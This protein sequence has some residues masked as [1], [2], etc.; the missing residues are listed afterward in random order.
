[1][2]R[3]SRSSIAL[4]FTLPRLVSLLPLGLTFALAPSGPGAVQ[5]S[6]LM[7]RLP[8]VSALKDH[9]FE[10]DRSV[11]QVQ[12]IAEVAPAAPSAKVAALR[13]ALLPWILELEQQFQTRYAKP[14]GLARS[15]DS[16]RLNVLVVASPDTLAALADGNAHR[17][18]LVGWNNYDDT[19]DAVVCDLEF[20]PSTPS[21]SRDRFLRGC[22][23]A[24][25]DDHATPASQRTPP[26]V[27]VLEGLARWFG[28][29]AGRT[30]PDLA[31]PRVG[32]TELDV[33]MAALADPNDPLHALYDFGA[34]LELRTRD[35][36][37][38]VVASLVKEKKLEATPDIDACYER[39]ATLCG[40]W[41]HYL[42]DI[43]DG[44]Y[45]RA[46]FTYLK[47][48]SNGDGSPL[49]LRVALGL[50]EL[51]PLDDAFKAWAAARHRVLGGKSTV[52]PALSAVA[53]MSQ[54]LLPKAEAFDAARMAIAPS[55]VAAR[56]AAALS[57]ARSGDIDG[58]RSE[59]EQLAAEAKD[60]PSLA[61]MQR[62]L[63][64]AT[65][66]LEL[67][68]AWIDATIKK[69]AKLAW[70]Q[71]G[72]KF[73]A[74]ITARTA[75]ALQLG[76]NSAGTTELRFSEVDSVWLAGL[77]PADQAAGEQA[78]KRLWPMALA[79]DEK[80][81]ALKRNPGT[82]NETL[83]ADAKERYAASLALGG[84][85]A[86]IG[87]LAAAGLPSDASAAQECLAR[88]TK[89]MEAG[90]ES[91]LVRARLE[92]INALVAGAAQKTFDAK[93]H[94]ASMAAAA[95]ELEGGKWK[96][97]WSFTG[98]EEL[99]AFRVEPGYLRGMRGEK[100]ELKLFKQEKKLVVQKGALRSQGQQLLR[101][102]PEFKSPFTL[103][104]SFAFGG[105]PRGGS[106]LLDV[107][108][109]ICD[110]QKG[111]LLVL[112]PWGNISVYAPTGKPQY[113]VQA[114]EILPVRIDRPYAVEVVH[115][116]AQVVLNVDGA[117]V[118][119]ADP[120]GRSSG[121]MLFLFHSDATAAM[122][123]VE[124]EGV[125]DLQALERDHLYTLLTSLGLF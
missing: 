94:L 44:R 50:K 58:A 54:N 3:P 7:A 65:A 125:L 10:I 85:A 70:N 23:L 86:Q 61:H 102:R 1:M 13:D 118:N 114:K 12:W 29:C 5:E 55:D 84:V 41:T 8:G 30:P 81:G 106:D 69:G 4:P 121:S 19:L 68:N 100:P 17:S 25:I 57:R 22:V 43:E 104:V 75:S 112:D 88:V 36:F 64:R 53:L 6:R 14:L 32:L 78:W 98:P 89:L 111:N 38:A 40:L 71:G 45:R 37:D 42:H 35:D 93:A 90:R 52:D 110:D 97:A 66:Y 62:D 73:S 115:D 18:G 20:D 107:E 108:F 92:M 49:R 16:P 47:S 24:L 96:L 74:A 21:A 15:S 72:K 46:L 2:L 101:L 34:L 99:N 105:V 123:S 87:E 80:L 51:V 76:P 48:V 77:I 124:V 82:E 67:R 113:L 116:G 60:H 109:G 59:L 39:F 117:Q 119:A 95:T 27:F 122:L 33:A 9:A 56:H 28:D 120:K 103:R 79:N 91:E 83:L 63:A 31:S 26:P 11:T